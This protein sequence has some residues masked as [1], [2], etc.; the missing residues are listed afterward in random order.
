MFDTRFWGYEKRACPAT[1]GL[2]AERLGKLDAGKDRQRILDMARAD[3]RTLEKVES[4]LGDC[5]TL[6]LARHQ[7]EEARALSAAY[8][9]EVIAV[10]ENRSAD[11]A[12]SAM[13]KTER[14]YS[15]FQTPQSAKNAA[16]LVWSVLLQ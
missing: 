12:A 4:E 11:G 5:S 13:Q 9:K 14:Y 15:T 7:L 2:L 16:S 6:S 3:L 1:P 10:L 8:L